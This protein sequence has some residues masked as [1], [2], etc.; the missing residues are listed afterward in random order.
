M[1]DVKEYK[2][3]SCGAPMDFDI[4]HQKMVCR[5]CS[6]KYDFDYIRSN[7]NEVTDEKLSDFD[8]VERTKYVWEPDM[9]EHIKEYVC[10]S[11]GGN[12]ITGSTFSSLKCPF[13]SHNVIIAVNFK[14]DFRPDKVIPF[15]VKADE[16]AKKYKENIADSKYAPKEFKNPEV[17]DNIFGCYIPM[18]LYSC[19]CET[20]IEN[21]INVSLKIK[22]YPILATDINKNL[23]YTIEP[24]MYD[25]AEDFTESCLT[26]FAAKRYSIGAENAMELADSKIKKTSRLR[27]YSQLNDGGYIIGNANHSD[28][29]DKQLLYYLVPV[30]FMNVKYK[31]K[32][33]NFAMNGQTGEFAHPNIPFNRKWIIDYL[34]II[35]YFFLA[36]VILV[37]LEGY[38]S[39]QKIIDIIDK[40]LFPLSYLMTFSP[41]IALIIFSFVSKK[42]IER[43]RIKEGSEAEIDDF[44]VGDVKIKLRSDR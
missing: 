30:W 35:L 12:I 19:N 29:T 1:S 36:F 2:C 16:F 37:L 18:W 38:S 17:L 33:Y 34:K 27:G 40:L 28:I 20:V 43:V 5:Y 7:F 24:F 44:I 41:F 10:P 31:G 6:N 11:C 26:G 13:C 15:K 42:H 3:P 14:G 23:F 22:D 25:E 39:N 4:T 32:I 21:D 8:W 9:A